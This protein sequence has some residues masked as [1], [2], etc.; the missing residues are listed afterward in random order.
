MRATAA[1]KRALQK[2]AD[3]LVQE[4]AT[5]LKWS[6]DGRNKAAGDILAEDKERHRA[7]L[8][9]LEEYI[10]DTPLEARSEDTAIE[11]CMIL[12]I[13]SDELDRRFFEMF[14]PS[15]FSFE[16]GQTVQ[17]ATYSLYVIKERK[18]TIE[19]GNIYRVG[20]ASWLEEKKL[21]LK[22]LQE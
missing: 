22:K 13:E 6:S 14:P 10:V 11:E 12:D 7:A 15:P 16:V 20:E 21:R 17:G 9:E 2:L 18:H 4:Q 1:E 19:L 5:Y 8:N 3:L